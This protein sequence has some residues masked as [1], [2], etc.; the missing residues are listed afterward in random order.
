[1]ALG[2]LGILDLF[3]HLYE[4]VYVP[5]AVYTEVVVRGS[6]HGYSDAHVAKLAIQREHLVVIDMDNSELPDEISNLPLDIGER[7]A[8]YLAIRDEADLILL[9]DLM[10]REEAHIRGLTVKGTLGVIVQAYRAGQLQFG[11]V[12]TLIQTIV[13]RDDIWIAA[14]LCHRVLK[15]LETDGKNYEKSS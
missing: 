15:S 14:E 4:R 5:T 11:E 10:A 13:T 9:D 1:M 2:K 7:Q 6:E 12:E 3:H 8:L